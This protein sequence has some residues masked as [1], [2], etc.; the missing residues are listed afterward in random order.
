MSTIQIILFTAM[1]SAVGTTLIIAN[2][3]TL[4]DKFKK[5]F[6]KN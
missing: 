2:N 6:N 4:L 1:I 3:Q 5:K